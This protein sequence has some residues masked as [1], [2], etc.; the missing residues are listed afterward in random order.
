M[1][2]E[3]FC[4]TSRTAERFDISIDESDRKTTHKE[5]VE[6]G[7]IISTGYI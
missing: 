5:K 6:N 3:Q 7:F 4:T 2:H 1:A